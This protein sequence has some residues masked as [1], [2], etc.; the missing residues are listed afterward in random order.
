VVRSGV[1][2]AGV[3]L[4]LLCLRL[5]GAA[6]PAPA[7]VTWNS[8]IARVLE[9]KCGACHGEGG[10]ARPRLDDYRTARSAGGA[11]KQAVLRRHMPRWYA[12]EG[13][14]DFG[15]DPTLT[16]H[17]VELIAQW[18]EG[19]APHGDP[20]P[21]PRLATPAAAAERP[22]LTLAVASKHRIAAGSHTFRLPSAIPGARWIRG[23][24]FEPGNRALIAG[25]VLALDHGP[26]LG[27]WVPGDGPTFLPDGVAARLPAGGEVRLTVYYHQPPAPAVDSSSV[28]LY[29]G[30]PPARRI[31][32]MVLPC[33]STRL[34]HA[35]DAL[36]IRPAIGSAAWSMA[37]LARNERHS[38]EPLG[39]FRKYP[40]QHPQTYRFRTPVALAKGTAIEV[41]ATHGECR[42]ELD[43]VR[44]DDRRDRR[45]ATADP[46]IAALPPASA[47]DGGYWCPMHTAVRSTVRGVCGQCGMG[48]V[49]V[50]PEIEG[51]YQLDVD[52][53]G[54]SASPSL[55]LVV[56]E[57]RTG[58][59]V[60]NFES[61]H[62]RLFHLFVVS[63]DLEQFAHVHP[64]AQADGSFL[65][66]PA[67][68]GHSP[69]QLYA[70]FLPAG[71]TPQMVRKAMVPRPPQHFSGSQAP[72]LGPQMAEQNDAGLRATT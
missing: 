61:V 57:P 48:L 66:T 62:E 32:H 51:R 20:A 50:R 49:P 10:H 31:E 5:P 63:D 26:P 19:G 72:H 36:A 18:V 58:A 8:T 30:P 22:D 7:G 69:Y 55:R 65:L 38:I 4:S 15:N 21:V 28:G 54:S 42:A 45:S 37:V 39:W 16:P 71:G 35:I 40:E 44:A 3:A 1:L 14:G 25:A 27:T 70:D 47:D 13:F 12:A 23:W 43:F 64:Q 68:R 59:I 46:G 11:I 29:F 60:R 2:V 17:E 24:T 6:H 34:P 53:V 52:V 41:G 56:R 33:G 67:P 9:R